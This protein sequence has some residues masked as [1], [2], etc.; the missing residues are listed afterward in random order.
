MSIPS[1]TLFRA[2]P[3]ASLLER[4]RPLT[5]TEL[6]DTLLRDL[7]RARAEMGLA[8]ITVAG[9]E[10]GGEGPSSEGDK[11]VQMV[12]TRISTAR[13]TPEQKDLLRRFAAVSLKELKDG[14]DLPKVVKAVLRMVEAWEAVN[15]DR[16]IAAE[17]PGRVKRIS[18]YLDEMNAREREA[19]EVGEKL[20]QAQT[21]AVAA[22][23]SAPAD[24]ETGGRR[25][26]V[27]A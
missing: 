20:Q 7:N 23:E 8:A 10:A 25:V 22:A 9:L 15:R 21:G 2:E 19:G 27:I 11:I 5:R 17:S 4:A 1:T 24:G 13:L 16:E 14:R 12:E 6:R 26:D 3:M 18:D